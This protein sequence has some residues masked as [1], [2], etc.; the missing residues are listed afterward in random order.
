M[1]YH[2][3]MGAGDN[4]L[5]ALCLRELARTIATERGYS[6]AAFLTAYVRFMTTPGSHDDTYAETFHRMF[7]LNYA[8]G[9]PPSECAGAPWGVK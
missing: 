8:A 4:T 1:H 9:R 7:F 3:G 6:P 2:Q 5:N